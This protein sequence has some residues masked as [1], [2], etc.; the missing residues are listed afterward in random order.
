[1]LRVHR[2]AL[3][4]RHAVRALERRRL[5]DDDDEGDD[6][7]P[8][9]ALQVAVTAEWLAVSRRQVQPVLRSPAAMPLIDRWMPR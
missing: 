9:W 2:N 5:Q 6:A 8:G 3:V 7:E 1:L 4:A